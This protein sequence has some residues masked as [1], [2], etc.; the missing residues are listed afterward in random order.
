MAEGDS[1]LERADDFYAAN[2]P[3]DNSVE[4]DV[5]SK[6]DVTSKAQRSGCRLDNAALEAEPS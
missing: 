2:Q 3:K 1:P 5:T 4:A 6:F